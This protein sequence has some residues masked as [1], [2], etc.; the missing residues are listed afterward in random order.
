MQIAIDG[1]A[2]S[3]KS[4][5]AKKVAQQLNFLYV[6][7][8]A[9]YRAA[10]WLAQQ[11]QVDFGDALKITLLLK[12]YPINFKLTKTQQL[13]FVGSTDVTQAIRTSII[14]QNVSQ[15]SALE[16]VRHLLVQQQRDLANQ[17]NVVM[18]GRDIGTVV[19][20]QAQVKIF[21]T[22]SVDE[23]AQRRYQE[24][25]A[26]NI[27]TPLDQLQQEIAT[28]DYKDSHRKISPLKQAV[29]A[30]LLDTTSL[31]IDQ[32]VQKVL[33]IIQLNLNK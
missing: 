8:G 3:G 31:D 27:K 33:E 24:N 19:L 13:V 29:D 18:D 11:N 9:M 20:P 23:R 15:V 16:E 30:I 32:V 22:A 6:D 5:I 28:R 17:N 4:T 21:M 12:K 26:R 14:S 1:P 25:L 7:T 2:S 10:T